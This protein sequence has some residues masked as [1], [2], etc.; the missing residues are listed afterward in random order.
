[1]TC[2]RFSPKSW[3]RLDGFRN[4]AIH[5][6]ATISICRG[7]PG[8]GDHGRDRRV[9]ASATIVALATILLTANLS[10]GGQSIGSAYLLP[11]SSPAFLGSTQFRCAR[12]NR[13]AILVAFCQGLHLVGAPTSVP[14]L[15]TGAAC[16][17]AFSL[18]RWEMTA[19]WVGGVRKFLCFDRR[20]GNGS[21][22][23]GRA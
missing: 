3:R 14:G 17:L 4:D 12:I 19:T 5:T 22:L 20:A 7:W 18:A 6:P 11:A 9:V 1:M 15:F 23:E 13:C 8:A 16:L 2:S 10:A 21:V